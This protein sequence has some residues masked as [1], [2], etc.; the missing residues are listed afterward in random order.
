MAFES[1]IT[2]QGPTSTRRLVWGTFTNGG[3][4]A[5]GDIDGGMAKCEFCLMQ[6]HKSAVV[7]TGSVVNETLPAAK[8]T[9][10]T[11]VNPTG[12]DGMFIML[13]F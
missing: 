10:C 6:Y 2:G 3:S 9:A 7:A 13:G 1:V 11:V 8:G 12:E 4:D 5:G